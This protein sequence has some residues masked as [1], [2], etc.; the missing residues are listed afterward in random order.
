MSSLRREF[1]YK[2][3]RHSVTKDGDRLVIRIMKNGK[4][5][6][7][8]DPTDDVKAAAEGAIKGK[9]DAR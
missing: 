1:T 4:W 9:H 6:E 3:Y 2:R 5:S 7:V 8:H